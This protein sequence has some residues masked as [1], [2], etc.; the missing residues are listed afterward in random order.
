MRTKHYIGVVDWVSLQ[1][2]S[3]RAMVHFTEVYM[4][5]QGYAKNHGTKRSH[6]KLISIS[7]HGTV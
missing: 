6:N 4:N 2:Q 7:M 3:G 1:T 5:I